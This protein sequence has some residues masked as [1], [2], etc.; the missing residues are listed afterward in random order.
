MAFLITANLAG[1]SSNCVR[2]QAGTLK[3]S[4]TDSSLR[5][6]EKENPLGLQHRFSKPIQ[7]FKDLAH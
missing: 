1:Y 5:K 2:V 4:K 6:K 3:F 7:L